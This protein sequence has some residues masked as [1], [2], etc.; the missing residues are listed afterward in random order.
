MALNF[1]LDIFEKYGFGVLNLS[2]LGFVSWKLFTNHL[3]HISKDLKSLNEKIVVIDD[4]VN[5]LKERVA[6]IEGRLEVKSRRKQKS[7][8]GLK[9]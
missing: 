1:F 4:N 9:K 8:G 5:G 6:T 3:A 2:L 7:Q